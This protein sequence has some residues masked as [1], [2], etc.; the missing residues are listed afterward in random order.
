METDQSRK[1]KMVGCSANSGVTTETLNQLGA[2]ELR[3]GAEFKRES[4]KRMMSAMT[5]C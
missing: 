1:A 2:L 3:G 4:Y 5:A